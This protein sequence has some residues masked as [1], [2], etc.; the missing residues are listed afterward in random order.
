VG[1]KRVRLHQLQAGCW[2][3]APATPGELD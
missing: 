2:Q 1:S 3:P